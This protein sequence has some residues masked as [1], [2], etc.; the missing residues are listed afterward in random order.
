MLRIASAFLLTL[1]L[2]FG[3]ALAEPKCSSFA[4]SPAHN[5]VKMPKAV[6]VVTN[7]GPADVA[8]HSDSL[9]SFDGVVAPAM[10]RNPLGFDGKNSDFF[11]VL[12]KPNE[13]A[14]FKVCR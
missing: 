3:S 1:V 9:G 14:H 11:V 2:H 5:R 10:G 8:I 4:L 6:F 12:V 13:D 7:D